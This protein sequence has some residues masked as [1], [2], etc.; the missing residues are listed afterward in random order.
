MV[1]NP[2]SPAALLQALLHPR[3]GRLHNKRWKAHRPPPRTRLPHPVRPHLRQ[4]LRQ[5]DTLSL[6]QHPPCQLERLRLSHRV[7]ISARMPLPGGKDARTR[8]K[9]SLPRPLRLAL[10]EI[11]THAY[12]VKPALRRAGSEA[13]HPRCQKPSDTFTKTCR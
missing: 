6:L 9:I 13:T 3:R 2:L 4:R 8:L 7:P 12:P 1:Q 5:R 11:G 10:A